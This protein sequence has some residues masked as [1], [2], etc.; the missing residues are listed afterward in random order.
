MK[1]IGI[2]IGGSWIKA[3]CVDYTFFNKVIDSSLLEIESKKIRNP[4]NEEKDS[5]K[6]L[7]ALIELITAFNL[8]NYKIAGIG[9]STAGIVNYH[10]TSV[11]A[12]SSHLNGLKNDFW[13]S[14]LER[15]FECIVRL[16][17]DADAAAIG[18][19]LLNYLKGDKTIGI[20]PIGT[21]LGFSIWK[22]GRRWRPGKI[23]PLLGEIKSYKSNFSSI[24]SAIKLANSDEN[25][26]LSNVLSKIEFKKERD[27]YIEKLTSIIETAVTLYG[28]DKV[29]ICGGLVDAANECNFKL[30]EELYKKNSQPINGLNKTTQIE[31]ALVGNKLNLLGALALINGEFIASSNNITYAYNTLATEAPYKREF[32]PEKMNSLDIIESL[33]DAEQEAGF[34]LKKSLKNIS[35]VVNL[36]IDKIEKGGRIIYVGAGTSGRVAAMDAVE[37]PCTYGFPKDK[38]ITLVSG[39]ISDSAIEIESD[40]EE[41]A[42][43]IAEILL[44]NIQSNDVVIGISASGS[45]Y[46]VQSA[47]AYAKDKGALS[48]MVQAND[49]FI[50]LNFCNYLISMNSGREIIAGSTRMKAGTATKK[51]LNFYSTTL[52]IKLGKVIGSYM[53][54]VVCTNDKLIRRAQKILKEIYNINDIEALGRLKNSDMHLGKVIK[55]IKEE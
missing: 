29:I 46:Y 24:V 3:T 31:T 9:I 6:I 13:R 32:C 38:I 50:K 4:L 8:Q 11:I 44:L 21:G 20:M 51:I 40:F 5:D 30:E 19:S 15:Q 35:K 14:K 17:N 12:T 53:V 7:K 23:L 36:S 25:S 54:D 1:Y 22:N 42:S 33:W 37:I 16:V 39:G 45:A 18:L 28:L 55:E 34:S 48:V 10:G 43:A 2:D 27:V 41:D 49:S 47:L 52:M 26:N